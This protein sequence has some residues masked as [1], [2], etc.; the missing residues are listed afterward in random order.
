M[1]ESLRTGVLDAV[2]AARESSGF[3]GLRG[4]KESPAEQF[5]SWLP[6][7]A[8][9]EGDNLFVNRDNL[10]FMLE[11][12]PQS[13]ADER[14]VEVLIS[15]YATCPK[16]AGIQ[17]HLFAS[18]HVGDLLES[19]CGNARLR[20]YRKDDAAPAADWVTAP[21]SGGLTP[22]AKPRRCALRRPGEGL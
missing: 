10:G 3:C 9:I 18:P 17:F 16:G 12:M 5:A 11:I 2:G 1:F 20:V 14:M 21:R 6:Y 4:N 19:N 13:G 22:W 8:Y 7:S 15:L